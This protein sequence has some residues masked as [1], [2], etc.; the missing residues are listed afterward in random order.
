M[1]AIETAELKRKVTIMIGGAAVDKDDVDK[2]GTLYG[3]T[4]EAVDLAKKA[5]QSK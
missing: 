5:I 3:D 2:I 4:R 1:A